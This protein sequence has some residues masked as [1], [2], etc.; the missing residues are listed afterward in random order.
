MERSYTFIF[1]EKIGYVDYDRFEVQSTMYF[2]LNT[3]VGGKLEAAIVFLSE[4]RSLIL[5]NV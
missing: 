4:F 2:T 3:Q 5:K 1:A